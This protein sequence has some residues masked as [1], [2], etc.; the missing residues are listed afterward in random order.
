MNQDYL[1]ALEDRIVNLERDRSTPPTQPRPQAPTPRLT[2]IN[3][4]SPLGVY[5]VPSGSTSAK[6]NA[7]PNGTPARTGPGG[8]GPAEAISGFSPPPPANAIDGMGLLLAPQ[9]QTPRAEPSGLGFGLAESEVYG[10]MSGISFHHMLLER[11]LPGYWCLAPRANTAPRPDVGFL[12]IPPTPEIFYAERANL[13]TRAQAQ[14]LFDW[15]GSYTWRVYPFIDMK[16]LRNSYDLLLAADDAAL[17]APENQ[18]IICLHFVVFAIVD[19][20]SDDEY[21]PCNVGYV[22]LRMLRKHQDW[23]HSTT[24]VQALLSGAMLMQG[25]DHPGFSWDLLGYAIRAGYAVGLHDAE[26]GRRFP[27]AERE[28]RNRAWWACY[29]FDRLVTVS[30]ARPSAI[31]SSGGGIP[32]PEIMEGEPAASIEFFRDSIRLHQVLADVVSNPPVSFRHASPEFVRSVV[33]QTHSL[34]QGY[35]AWC[36]GAHLNDVGHPDPRLATVLTLR[37]LTM[38]LLLHRRVMLAAIHDYI[39]GGARHGAVHSETSLQHLEAR[40]RDLAFG[41]SLGIIIETAIHTINILDHG[42]ADASLSAP[43]YQ[44][45]YAMNAF[46]SLLATL[47]LDLSQWSWFIRVPG[48]PIVQALHSSLRVVR[49][50]SDRFQ[51]PSAKQAVVMIEH[52]LGTLGIAEPPQQQPADQ[53]ASSLEDL[54]QLDID[55]L[56]QSLEL[57]IP[58]LY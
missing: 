13:P 10:A 11:L 37:G 58:D 46:T 57:Q 34:E 48:L 44:L 28:M 42:H 41:I 4:P 14:R 36:D 53:P 51:R 35:A 25:I 6:T 31:T 1:K 18:P 55:E 19:S 12:G 56:W 2:Q 17:R 38:R 3:V 45:F 27:A 33:S 24:K 21:T 47:L 20:M 50:I 26:T 22:A 15:F 5:D 54:P 43:W 30:I 49:K 40:H 8:G 52:V 32:L 29:T 39:P 9:R 23:P 7:E 16:A